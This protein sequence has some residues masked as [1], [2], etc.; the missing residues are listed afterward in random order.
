[1]FFM[2]LCLPV[3]SQVYT[4]IGIFDNSVKGQYKSTLGSAIEMGGY[5]Y[6]DKDWFKLFYGVRVEKSHFGPEAKINSDYISFLFQPKFYVDDTEGD[7]K[8]ILGPGL[9]FGGAVIKNGATYLQSWYSL[10]VGIGYGSLELLFAFEQSLRDA[11]FGKNGTQNIGFL[12]IVLR[13]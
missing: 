4:R 8:M 2:I 11:I 12:S 9:R 13:Y 3:F 6:I 10:N 7:I 1:M 5:S